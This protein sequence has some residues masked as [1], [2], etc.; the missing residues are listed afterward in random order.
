MKVCD[1][2]EQYVAQSLSGKAVFPA[3]RNQSPASRSSRAALPQP[4]R[5]KFAPETKDPS[6]PARRA[7]ARAAGTA[8]WAACARSG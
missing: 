3:E 5:R 1:E 7:K 4:S 8:S 6:Q 2:F